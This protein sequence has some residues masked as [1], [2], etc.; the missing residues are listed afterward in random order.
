MTSGE[1]T[2]G[3][4][5]PNGGGQVSADLSS[6]GDALAALKTLWPGPGITVY[7]GLDNDTGRVCAGYLRNEQ[8]LAVRMSGRTVAEAVDN[9]R[10]WTNANPLTAGH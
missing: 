6:A 8:R 7:V 10:R 9:A 3:G 5:A 2:V 1:A 4:A